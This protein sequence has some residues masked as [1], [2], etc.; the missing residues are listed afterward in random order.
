MY[1]LLALVG[2][3]VQNDCKRNPGAKCIFRLLAL[4]FLEKLIQLPVW[5][6]AIFNWQITCTPP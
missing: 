5:E 6:N 2:M 4:A 3:W 1:E